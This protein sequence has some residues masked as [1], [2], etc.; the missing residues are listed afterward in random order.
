M[1]VEDEL[2]VD[3]EDELEKED[4]DYLEND[5]ISK[6]QFNYNKSSCLTNDVPGIE[7]ADINEIISVAP[8][9]GKVPRSILTDPNWDLKSHPN[10]DPTGEFNLNAERSVKITNQQFFEQ[11]IFNV[12]T[13]Y[14]KSMSYIFAAI[15]YIE[16]K[17][18]N[19][20]I[21]ISFSRGRQ[22]SNPE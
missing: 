13:R 21:N 9:E 14:S 11:K 4:R 20:R 22:Q 12:D 1:D 5:V 8:G 3:A 6:Q 15:N 17:Q 7:G 2:E 10:L 18:L 19:D 16:T